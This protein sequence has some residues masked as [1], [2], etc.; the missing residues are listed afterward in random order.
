MSNDDMPKTPN[1]TSSASPLWL[2][3]VFMI[4]A[5]ATTGGAA[6][7]V[8]GGVQIALVVYVILYSSLVTAIFFVMFWRK[9]GIFYPPS[10]FEKS[11][12]QDY[13]RALSGIPLFLKDSL[14]TAEGNPGDNSAMFSLI[15]GLLEER[16][17][18]TLLL[19]RELKGNTIDY[20]ATTNPMDWPTYEYMTK[21][22]VSFGNLDLRKFEARLKGTNLIDIDE[23][24]GKIVLTNFGKD[25]ANWL[26]E[27]GRSAEVFKSEL[28]NFGTNQELVKD[29]RS[30]ME[31]SEEMRERS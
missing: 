7:M 23:K 8:T 9:P 13:H 19:M 18:Q 3:G 26:H 11:T 15:D 14:S 30:V 20:D 17:R 21:R 16:H 24:N 4:F 5:Q 28:G 27:N 25:F 22:E 2:I 29:G 10:D 1:K 12:V 6:V 31:I